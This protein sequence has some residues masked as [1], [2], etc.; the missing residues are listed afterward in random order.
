MGA[1]PGQREQ[2]RQ[3]PLDAQFRILERHGRFF[4]VTRQ[5]VEGELRVENRLWA[6]L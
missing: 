6:G 1:C 2:R 3:M 4:A 5:H